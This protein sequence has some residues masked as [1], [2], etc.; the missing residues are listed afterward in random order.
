M[1]RGRS[2]PAWVFPDP[3]RL[4]DTL[5]KVFFFFGLVW[6]GLFSEK[7]LEI[8]QQGCQEQ[9]DNVLV[10]DA[11]VDEQWMPGFPIRDEV[12]E[13][14]VSRMYV[15]AKFLNVILNH[16]KNLRIGQGALNA[17]LEKGS[18]DCLELLFESNPE[19]TIPLDLTLKATKQVRRD[20]IDN[21]V[22]KMLE[23][24][25]RFG[26]K[27]EFTHQI[28]IGLSTSNS[29]CSRRVISSRYF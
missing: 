3:T 28:F 27:Q 22:L 21:K 13:S 25:V 19:L 23:V 1:E 14:P 18:T 17:C 4:N 24:L 20:Y 9:V 26:K 15:G 5:D 7:A 2:V 8:E 12:V 16:D 11:Q 10:L 29:N 6:F